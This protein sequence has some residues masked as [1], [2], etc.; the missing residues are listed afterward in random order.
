MNLV[1]KIYEAA[2]SVGFLKECIWHPSDGSPPRTNMI[3]LQAPDDTV[4][5]NLTVTTDTTMSYP[6]T[7]FDGLAPRETVEIEGVAF[8]VREIRAVGDGSEMRAKLTR[9]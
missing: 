9:I 6:A 2:A 5:D 7:I 3:G 4:L 1:E 8:Q